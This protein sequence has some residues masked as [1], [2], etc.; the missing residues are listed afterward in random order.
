MRHTILF[1]RI[2]PV[3]NVGATLDFPSEG[4]A[5]E[6][7]SGVQALARAWKSCGFSAVLKKTRYLICVSVKHDYKIGQKIWFVKR[8]SEKKWK[9]FKFRK[10]L[11][12]KHLRRRGGRP[13]SQVVGCQVL[14][15]KKSRLVLTTRRDGTHTLT[16]HEKFYDTEESRTAQAVDTIARTVITREKISSFVISFFPILK[17]AVQDRMAGLSFLLHNEQH[18]RGLIGETLLRSELKPSRLR[19]VAWCRQPLLVD[20]F[21]HLGIICVGLFC[22]NLV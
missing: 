18:G 6:L 12:I 20:P 21:Y 4:I 15:V 3:D 2:I 5:Y 22:G 14:R 11:I 13:A 7:V 17:V 16:N 1:P 19:D 10:L 8:F 9:K